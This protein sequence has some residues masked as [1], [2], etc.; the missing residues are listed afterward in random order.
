MPGLTDAQLGA[1]VATFNNLVQTTL[2]APAT[3]KIPSA[4]ADFEQLTH[5]QMAL[6]W[7][8]ATGGTI[9]PPGA[10]GPPGAT[11]ATGPAGPTGATGAQGG[12]GAQGLQ[13]IQG[14][15]GPQGATGLQGPTGPIGP[16]GPAGPGLDIVGSVANAAALPATGISGDA[17][18]TTDTGHV[19]TWAQSPAPPHW[20]DLGPIQGPAGTPGPAGPAGP[21]GPQGPAGPGVGTLTP[22][23]VLFGSPSNSIAQNSGFQYNGTNIVAYSTFYHRDTSYFGTGDQSYFDPSGDCLVGGDTWH[24]GTTTF[25]SAGQANIDP[26]GNAYVGNMNANYIIDRNT[27]TG[28]TAGVVYKASDRS[29][30]SAG[31]GT[32]WAQLGSVLLCWGTVAVANP[33]YDQWVWFGRINFPVGYTGNVVVTGTGYTGGAQPDSPD[34]GE[35]LV[36]TA[37]TGGFSGWLRAGDAPGGNCLAYWMAVG[38]IG[39]A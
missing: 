2:A 1:L 4:L 12:Q 33:G 20:M 3:T 30:R 34:Q 24:K 27:G 21:A 15:P 22:G 5:A 19:W 18:I 7:L 29:L 31:W 36:N 14:V 39:T 10:Q 9:G 11:G 38:N 25:G 26:S 28:P 13:G 17:W 23:L 16:S 37:D 6:L 8:Q 35:F 32:G